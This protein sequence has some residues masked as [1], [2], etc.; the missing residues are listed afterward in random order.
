MDFLLAPQPQLDINRG[1]V[2]IL[3]VDRAGFW[4]RV[5]AISID[6][7]LVGLIIGTLT[8]TTGLIL[9]FWGVSSGSNW[10]VYVLS[11]ALS[12]IAI[13][14]AYY[15][16][17]HGSSGQTVGKLIFGLRVVSNTGKPLTY[18]Q[19]FKRWLGCFA[20]ALSLGIGYLRA[21]LYKDRLAWHDIIAQT[22]VVKL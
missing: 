16:L 9:D 15:T 18:G 20:S 1:E 7:S 4:V 2:D 5:K 19:A 21:A 10:P 12:G 22:L 3:L 8:T 17:F 14:G 6:Q 11:L 13:D